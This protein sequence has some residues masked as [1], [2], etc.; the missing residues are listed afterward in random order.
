[1]IR[2]L[3]VILA[4]FFLIANVSVYC[5]NTKSRTQ[6]TK[7]SKSSS[8]HSKPKMAKASKNPKIYRTN[9]QWKINSPFGIFSSFPNKTKKSS[10]QKFDHFTEHNIDKSA[11]T[12]NEKEADLEKKVKHSFWKRLSYLKKNSK[13][14]LFIIHSNFNT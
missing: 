4:F 7:S 12:E 14:K 10:S 2:K 11:G 6:P 9:R 1:M 5:Q 8:A 13:I 3:Y